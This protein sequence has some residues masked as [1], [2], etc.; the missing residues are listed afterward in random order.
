MEFTK[1]ELLKI[2][3]AMADSEL[4]VRSLGLTTSIEFN[5]LTTKI[6]KSLTQ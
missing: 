5:L 3:V 1:E 4:H 6:K 2:W